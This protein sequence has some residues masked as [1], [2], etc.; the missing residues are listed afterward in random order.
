M[1][2]KLAVFDLD[3][4]LTDT[5]RYH[6][7]AWKQTLEAYGIPVDNEVNELVK[8]ISRVDSLK[9]ILSRAK[10]P[11]HDAVFEGLLY[12]KN[13]TYQEMISKL[14]KKDVLPGILT[15]LEELKQAKI[16]CVIASASKSAEYILNQL[17]IRAFFQGVVDPA[18]VQH[19]K[20][21]PDI[22]LKACAMM[23]VSVGQAVGFEDARAGIQAIKAAGMKAVGIGH[24]DLMLDAPNRYYPSTSF[25]HRKDIENMMKEIEV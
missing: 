18:S 13:Q 1:Q 17:E 25:L 22:F 21:A 10:V 23:N 12:Q 3:G 4:V 11:L 20:P 6:F 5:A 9:L 7:L 2:W 19:G 24:K 14:S 8:G 16:P 15:F